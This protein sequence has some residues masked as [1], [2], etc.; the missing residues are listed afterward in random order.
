L[1]ALEAAGVAP[2]AIRALGQFSK[3]VERSFGAL[4]SGVKGMETQISHLVGT[5][6][7][8]LSAYGA[9]DDYEEGEENEEEE[10]ETK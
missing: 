8:L 5:M 10:E 9:E 4:D 1:K 3:G 7:A 6:D 2:E